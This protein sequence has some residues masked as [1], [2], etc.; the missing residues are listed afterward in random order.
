MATDKSVLRDEHKH[1]KLDEHIARVA[2]LPDSYTYHGA[3]QGHCQILQAFPFELDLGYTG[4]NHAGFDDYPVSSS[5]SRL[6][7][8][9]ASMLLARVFRSNTYRALG[10]SQPES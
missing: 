2:D 10:C 1:D 8:A 5:C 9:S 7:C 3:E 4:R 6:A